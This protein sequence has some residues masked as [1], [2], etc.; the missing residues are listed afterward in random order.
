VLGLV[1][2]YSGRPATYNT[3]R[4]VVEEGFYAFGLSGDEHR[5]EH[6]NVVLLIN[7]ETIF[8]LS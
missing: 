2:A 7:D 3:S 5:K 6:A 8:A 1:D 4:P